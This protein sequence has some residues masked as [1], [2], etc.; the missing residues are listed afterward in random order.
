MKEIR[1]GVAVTMETKNILKD[2]QVYIYIYIKQ[3]LITRTSSAEITAE[4]ENR[5]QN[6]KDDLITLR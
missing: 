5:G 2:T 1:I 6:F 4:I 3:S